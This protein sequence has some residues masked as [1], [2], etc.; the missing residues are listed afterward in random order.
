MKKMLTAAILA[1]SLTGLS[2]PSAS[3]GAFGLFPHGCCCNC[4]CSVCIRQ[5]NAFSPVCSGCLFCDGCFPFGTPGFG[6]CGPGGC[7]GYGPVGL[8]YM[9]SVGGCGPGGCAANYGE[10]P[11]GPDMSGVPPTATVESAPPQAMPVGPTSAAQFGGGQPAMYPA[12][13]RPAFYPGYGFAPQTAGPVQGSV[14]V[15]WNGR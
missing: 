9:G 1:L 13:Y 7:G 10:L 3:A 6:G 4:G 12:A 11:A 14:P 8:N 15:Y 5:Y 2:A